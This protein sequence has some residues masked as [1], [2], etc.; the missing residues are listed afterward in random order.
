MTPERREPAEA[1]RRVAEMGVMMRLDVFGMTCG[2][3]EAAVR[4]AIE[5]RDPAARVTASAADDRVEI[6]TRLAIEDAV[7]AIEAA[8]YEARPARD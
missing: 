6:E 1:V 8:G 5:A 2:G 4:R 3:C 7:A